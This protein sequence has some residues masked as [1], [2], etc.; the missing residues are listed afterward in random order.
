MGRNTQTCLSV[1]GLE[2]LSEGVAE[3]PDFALAEALR[4]G[5]QTAWEV[6]GNFLFQKGQQTGKVKPVWRCLWILR[7]WLSNS[8]A[9]SRP[10]KRH[11]SPIPGRKGMRTFA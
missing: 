8:L 2:E 6:L 7:D 5:S 4:E 11:S 3:E 9:Y 1:Q 10:R